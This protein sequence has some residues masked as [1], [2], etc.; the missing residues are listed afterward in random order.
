MPTRPSIEKRDDGVVLRLKVQ[1]RASRESIRIQ[2]D[3]SI[4][5]ALN[6]P[7]VDGAANRALCAL[8]AKTLGVAKSAVSILTG[9]TSRN[10]ALAIEGISLSEARDKLSKV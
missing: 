5:V 10:K 9:K 1:P 4:R 3:G 7:A 8:I 6:A 2:G